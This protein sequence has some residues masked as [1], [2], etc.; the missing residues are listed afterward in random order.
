MS[1]VVVIIYLIILALIICVKWDD[2]FY[3]GYKYEGLNPNDYY[4]EPADL[5]HIPDDARGKTKEEVL[6]IDDIKIKYGLKFKTK[7]KM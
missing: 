2:I 4:Y 6:G 1:R 3:P 5:T 7:G